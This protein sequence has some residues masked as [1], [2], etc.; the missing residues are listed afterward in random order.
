[1]TRHFWDKQFVLYTQDYEREAT[2]AVQN[3]LYQFLC[4]PLIRN[5]LG[6]VKSS[7]DFDFLINNRGILIVNLAKQAIGEI[8]ANLLGSLIVSLLQSAAMRRLALPE[9]KRVPFYGYID[10]FH[11]FTTQTFV[12]LLPEVR[13]SKL[14]LTMAHQFTGQLTRQIRDAV[15]GTV[16]TIIAFQ[17]G[18][19]DAVLLEKQYGTINEKHMGTR[20]DFLSLPSYQACLNWGI[21]EGVMVKTYPP[22]GELIPSCR[23]SHKEV[24]RAES[25]RR[26][27]R[28]RAQVEERI[29]RFLS[30]P[31]VMQ[32]RPRKARTKRR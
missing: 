5:V 19:D 21:N 30:R 20:R 3:K 1:M 4:N 6:Q 24:I 12:T 28:P 26:F 31:V 29:E 18:P 16:G 15:F 17:V 11:N 27:G 8:E 7:I 2:P 9:E 13:K 14:G 25:R 22:L 32:T 23:Y 10:E